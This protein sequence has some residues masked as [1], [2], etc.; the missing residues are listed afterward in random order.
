M[1]GYCRLNNQALMRNLTRAKASL[2]RFHSILGF[3]GSHRYAA[4]IL[5]LLATIGAAGCAT[6]P[7]TAP[8]PIS[9]A[10]ATTAAADEAPGQVV[11]EVPAT[12]VPPSPTSA[13]AST[14]EH[15]VSD[16]SVDAADIRLFPVPSII[17]GDRVTVQIYPH[18]P[19]QLAVEKVGVDIY[20]DGEVVSSDTLSTRNWEGLAE[21]VY[22]WVW[23]ST[24]KPGE[25]ELRIVLDAQDQIQ[26][27][28]EDPNNNETVVP[29]K[30]R[31]AGERPL[32]ERDVTWITA[33][34]DCCE[35]HVLQQ[36][37]AYRDL[38]SLQRQVE[39]AVSQAASRL[40]EAPEEP[41]DVYFI[42]RTIGQGGFASSEMVVTYTD[43]P[44][45]GGQ[46][47]ELLVHEAVH[48]L[49]RQFAP[50]RTK[51]LAEGIAVWATGGH[52]KQEDL[53]TRMAALLQMNEYIPL[54]TLANEFYPAQHEI[55][56]LEAGALVAYLVDRGGYP[57]FRDFYSNT[58]A[59]D[60]ATE[61]E[62][63]D[64][65]LQSYYGLSLDEL[66]MEWLAF[67]A[68]KQPS[69]A[70]IADLQ[71]T[72]RFYETARRYQTLYDP[73]A[74]FRTAWLP[75]PAE[76]QERG[77]TADLT[78]HPKAEINVTIEIML[79]AAEE[80]RQAQD[81]NR[82]NVLLDSVTRIL[83]QSGAFN[84]PLAASYQRIVREA[85]NFGYEPQQVLLDGGNAEVLVTTASGFHLSTI[86]LEQ[87]SGDWVFLAN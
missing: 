21:G 73:S 18:V 56:Y 20:V 59:S 28:D 82:A 36:T 64:V 58:T 1:I 84:D 32:E 12:A 63:L 26:I 75:H 2:A 17:S 80:A 31:K 29:F 79:R 8:A 68:T 65:N 52:Y 41:I 5:L 54:A 85:M 57:T 60:G 10:A 33:L 15:D 27:G 72:V 50:Q 76:V 46:L 66:E 19:A 49:D 74:Y 4:R 62:A 71:T 37:A 39:S 13:A 23:D 24:G 7:A 30:V 43:R 9:T 11:N 70:E 35:L 69:E 45:I 22:E 61:A 47:Y 67:L 40:N 51:L 25:H 86:A 83:D 53:H 78:R 42:E 77:N 81:F 6:L 14:V 55:G 87:R 34:V 48:V 3:R 38:G 16:L 44:Y